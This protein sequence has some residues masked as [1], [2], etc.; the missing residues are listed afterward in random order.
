MAWC[1]TG[2]KPSSEQMMA[3]FTDAYMCYLALVNL[4]HFIVKF[5][6]LDYQN[7]HVAALQFKLFKTCCDVS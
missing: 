3:K 1:E 5:A 7:V 6:R 4:G 2:N